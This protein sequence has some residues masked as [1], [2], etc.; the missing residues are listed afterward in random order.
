MLRLPPR[1]TRTDTLFPYTTLFRSDVCSSDLGEAWLRNFGGQRMRSRLRRDGRM[2][3][4]RLGP[5]RFRFA[6][7]AQ[8]GELW[9]RVNGV[10]LFGVL[11]LPAPLFDGVYCREGEAEGRY[12]FEVEAALPLCGRLIRYAGWL[13]HAESS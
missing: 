6:L 13:E 10:K 4:E 9:W 3:V 11:P 7:H 8:D 1:S 12:T 2:L 5:V